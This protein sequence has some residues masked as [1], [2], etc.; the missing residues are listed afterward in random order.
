MAGFATLLGV[1]LAALAGENVQGEPTRAQN[2]VLKNTDPHAADAAKNGGVLST[3]AGA[4]I[5]GMNAEK[6]GVN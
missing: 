1:G 2:E 6:A 5:D 3:L 4:F